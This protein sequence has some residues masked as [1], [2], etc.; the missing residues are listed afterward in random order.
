MGTASTSCT[1]CGAEVQG[2]QTLCPN[3][4]R[5][6]WYTLK[7]VSACLLVILILAVLL[8]YLVGY[9]DRTLAQW[10]G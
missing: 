2:H 4:Y 10:F 3:C 5:P 9:G 1:E 6:R 7:K 8:R